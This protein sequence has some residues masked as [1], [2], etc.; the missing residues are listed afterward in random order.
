VLALRDERSARPPLDLVAGGDPVRVV[1][2]EERGELVLAN[3]RQLLLEVT[4]E[5]GATA[6]TLFLRGEF[7][8]KRVEH[9]L[10]SLRNQQHA[11]VFFALLQVNGAH[12]WWN[13]QTGKLR[14]T[15]SQLAPDHLTSF[16]REMQFKTP[17]IQR[18]GQFEDTIVDKIPI[19]PAT[20]ADAQRWFEWLLAHRADQ[21]QWPDVYA[22]GATELRQRFPGFQLQVPAQGDFARQMRGEERPMS[23][24]WHLQAPLDLDGGMAR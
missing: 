13:G 4:F 7:D 1:M 10:P 23:A 19:E 24:Y 16:S 14:A 22:R 17:T 9:S 20:P 8:G 15:Y 12:V 6:G 18:L 2:I 3:R 5:P 21:T 11:S